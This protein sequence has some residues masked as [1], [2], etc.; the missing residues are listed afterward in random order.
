MKKV[1]CKHS[2]V[3]SGKYFGLVCCPYCMKY[4]TKKIPA[5]WEETRERD[6]WLEV[7]IEGELTPHF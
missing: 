7:K 3:I 2:F 4:F 6:K 1:K 5:Y